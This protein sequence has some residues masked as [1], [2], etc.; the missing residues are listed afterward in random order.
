M[1]AR[2]AVLAA[3]VLLVTAAPAA[4]DTAC[5]PMQTPP[6]FQG[7]VPKL[8]TSCPRPAART[9]RSRPTRPTATWTRSTRASDR[10]IT[11]AL[12]KKSWQDRELRWAID[13]ASR[14]PRSP[15]AEGDRQGRAGASRPKAPR[16]GSLA[17]SPSASRPSCGS[18]RTCTAAR[19][20]APT[21]RCAC[22][23]SSPTA[24]TAPPARSSTTRSSC[25]CRSR[26]R[27]AASSTPAR[28]STA[29]T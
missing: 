9:A 15:V 21:A 19:S 29:S 10:V 18:P 5:D 1:L 28:T 8:E 24:P 12:D 6:E 11:G 7:G 2:L 17:R 14:P 13:R 16:H 20:P 22:S 23:T 3:V 25:C 27:T 26:T 4:A